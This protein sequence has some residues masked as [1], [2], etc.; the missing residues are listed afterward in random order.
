[1]VFNG[2]LLFL[3]QALGMATKLTKCHYVSNATALSW[4]SVLGGGYSND[5]VGCSTTGPIAWPVER[6]K[7]SKTR[8]RQ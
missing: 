1:M 2:F 5:S 6:F 4:G 3:L 7:L 8:S